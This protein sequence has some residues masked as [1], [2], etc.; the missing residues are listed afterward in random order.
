MSSEEESTE[1]PVFW[2]EKGIDEFQSDVINLLKTGKGVIQSY[3]FPDRML[4]NFDGKCIAIV[5]LQTGASGI[6]FRQVQKPVQGTGK[7]AQLNLK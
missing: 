4:I 1:I 7:R 2:L 5:N 6:V 3:F